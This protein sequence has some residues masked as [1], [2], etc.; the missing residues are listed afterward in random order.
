MVRTLEERYDAY[1]DDQTI[2]S[3]LIGEDG[4]IPTAEQLA[5][6][7]ERFLA[8]RQPGSG[9]GAENGGDAENAAD[10]ENGADGAV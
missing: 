9:T 10:D 2:R 8:E 3:P 6:E 7:L 4:M 5:S 1:M